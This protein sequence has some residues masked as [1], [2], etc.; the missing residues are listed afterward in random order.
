MVVHEND[1]HFLWAGGPIGAGG[2]VDELGVDRELL[3]RGG[4]A[5]EVEKNSELGIRG[6]DFFDS[7]KGDVNLWRG[8]AE[9]RIAF[10]GHQH[11]TATLGGDEVRA[12]D[13]G[14][15]LQVFVPHENA[16]A[17]GDCFRVV[18]VVAEAFALEALRDIASVFVDDRL[19]D[20]AGVVAIDLNDVFAEVGLDGLNAHGAE[21][22]VQMNL[23]GDH[24]LRLHDL[25]GAG[26][27]KNIRHRAAGVL[28]SDGVVNMGA[29]AFEALL[30]LLEVGIE[31]LDRVLADLAGEA[32]E[33]VGSG[34]VVTKNTVT[35]L[36]AGG[37]VAADGLLNAPVEAAGE[38]FD[39]LFSHDGG[40]RFGGFARSG[41][42]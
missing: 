32:A 17:A 22:V 15:R 18:V 20:V 41:V 16:G 7:H 21:V 39:F 6:D 27:L 30:G 4:A 26:F 5:K 23:L 25:F 42:F 31:V 40:G 10:V 24:T 38:E 19:D 11:E 37:T 14:I 28:R 8:E 2:A 13:A 3:A 1:M 9:A 35:L 33:I 36:G 29:L 34:V 12:G